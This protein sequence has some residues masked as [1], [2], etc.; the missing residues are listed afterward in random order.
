MP[1]ATTDSPYAPPLPEAYTQTTLRENWKCY[2]TNILV[3]FGTIRKSFGYHDVL[4]HYLS[5]APFMLYPEFG[6][7]SGIIAGF[8]AQPSL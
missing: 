1:P 5:L 7:D 6:F 8:Q 2:I 4:C 3:A